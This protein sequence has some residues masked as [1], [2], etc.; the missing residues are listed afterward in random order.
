MNLIVEAV[1]ENR[2]LKPTEA[3]PLKEHEK[4]RLTVMRPS[5]LAEQTYGLM[6]WTSDAETLD[7][8]WSKISKIDCSTAAT[9]DSYSC[10]ARPRS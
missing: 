5:S 2:I 4:V 8:V 1:Y 7:R 9:A 6:G 10:R 3:L